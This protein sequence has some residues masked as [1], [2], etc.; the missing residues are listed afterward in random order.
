MEFHTTEIEPIELLETGI[1]HEY[2][3]K[4]VSYALKQSIG[5][6]SASANRLRSTLDKYITLNGGRK[7]APSK[8]LGAVKLDR[9]CEFTKGLEPINVET[10]VEALAQQPLIP[11]EDEP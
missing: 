11:G 7:Q 3:P 10:S 2:W 8:M 1:E 9:R 5:K 6:S 4:I